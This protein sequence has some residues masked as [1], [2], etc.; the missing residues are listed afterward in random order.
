M[1]KNHWYCIFFLSHPLSAMG[2]VTFNCILG[3]WGFSWNMTIEADYRRSWTQPTI[4][5][6]HQ[7][8]THWESN[9]HT[10]SL[11]LTHCHS[12]T[13]IHT[14]I[15]RLTHRQTHS[16]TVLPSVLFHSHNSCTYFHL[17][18]FDGW[19]NMPGCLSIVG[20]SVSTGRSLSFW[21]TYYSWRW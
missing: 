9:F 6:P 13:F 8:I 19:M 11:S 2:R 17:E 18:W 1:S 20:M 14:H 15:E 12:M 4:T 3:F 16:K 7:S 5:H 10:L 21:Q